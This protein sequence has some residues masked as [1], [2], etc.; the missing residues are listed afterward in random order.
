[1]NNTEVKTNTGEM[2][3]N[4][5]IIAQMFKALLPAQILSCATASLSS[6]INGFLI[7]NY[8]SAEAM[9][10]LGLVSP[11]TTVLTA[12]AAVVSG[13]MRILCGRYIG[14]G[15]QKKLNSVLSV[16]IVMLIAVGAVLTAGGLI[17]ASPLASLLGAK[18]AANAA[19]AAYI[20]GL[21]LG[22]IPTIMVPGFM[23]FLQMLND[24][25]YS[26]LSTLVLAAS[27]LLLG[28]LNLRAFNGGVFGMGVAT[29]IS[30]F[31]TIIF[32]A[33]RVF[34]KKSGVHFERKSG[35]K[36]LWLEIIK[37]GSPTAV[38]TLLYAVRNVVVNFMALNVRGDDAV[39]ALAIYNSFAGLFDA[40]NVG[41]GAVALALASVFVGEKDNDALKLL[42]KKTI[43]YGLIMGF[44]KFILLIFAGNPIVR[45]F[46]ASGEVVGLAYALTLCFGATMPLNML[47]QAVVAQYQSL[48]R[49]RFVNILYVFS[50]IVFPLAFAWVFSP[51]IGIMGIW[52][53]FG[54]AELLTLVVV[55]V[56]TPFK[57]GHMPKKLSDFL[58]LDSSVEKGSRMSISVKTLE[59]VVNVSESL[60]GFCRENGV[61]ERRSKLCGLCLE[62]MAGNVVEHGF[63]K[64]KKNR[65]YT[66]DIFVYTDGD[67]L[68]MRLRDNAPGFDP[69]TK[70]APVDPEDP[71]KNI[72]IRVVSK[73]A[74]EMNYQTSF[75]MNVVSI[76]L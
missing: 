52:L 51:I 17:F 74:K 69:R 10:A 45:L 42:F 26:F 54:V 38:A 11:V 75:G 56:A 31:I 48:G 66:V 16:S 65:E 72:G 73:V 22:I 50:A 71:T 34:R 30:Q 46:G 60:I 6:I 64:G 1:M 44:A 57:I 3:Y 32:L 70:L 55:A 76:V 47:T 12:I 61:D 4:G 5:R 25:N 29:S 68:E 23:I 58:W 8:L 15:D 13:G 24:S 19:T 39:S 53:C 9:V 33:L 43:K 37:L 27:S 21:S 28:L 59:E 41:T 20:R 62:E 67:E 35:E 2:K 18:G 36:N 49:I 40:V 63:T 14:R 7:G